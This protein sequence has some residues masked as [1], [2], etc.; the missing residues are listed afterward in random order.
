MF[1]VLV[2]G[3]NLVGKIGTSQYFENKGRK[4]VHADVAEYS[5]AVGYQLKL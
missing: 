2:K 4:A 1:L 3:L 5:P